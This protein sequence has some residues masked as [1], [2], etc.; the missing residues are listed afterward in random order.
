MLTASGLKKLQEELEELKNKKIPA[1]V[2]RLSLARAEG[3]LSENSAYQSAREEL[4]FLENRVAELEAIIDGSPVA[5][6]APGREGVAVG[7]TVTVAA[8]NGKK[9]VFS[10]VGDWEADPKAGKISGS[11]PIGRALLGKKPGDKAEVAAPAGK[12]IYTILSIE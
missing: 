12:I 2:E 3:D 6:A 1:V 5:K 8:D 10:L 11:S 7:H 9:M 4:E